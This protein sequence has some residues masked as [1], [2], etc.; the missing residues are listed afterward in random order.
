MIRRRRRPAEIPFSLDSFLDVIANVV[1][2]I[3]KLILVAWVG[4][5]SYHAICDL[6]DG[7]DSSPSA[8]ANLKPL[9]VEQELEH[10]RNELNQSQARLLEQLRQVTQLDEKTAQTKQELTALGQQ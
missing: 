9:A 8:A 10:R 4:A 2:I 7:A 5:R 6:T 1:G 3:I